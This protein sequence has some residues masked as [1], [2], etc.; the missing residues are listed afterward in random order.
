MVHEE[1]ERLQRLS[2]H[3]QVLLDA[4]AADDEEVGLLAARPAQQMHPAGQANGA[5]PAAS[6]S[7]TAA[8]GDSYADALLPAASPGELAGQV[9]GMQSG[10]ATTRKQAIARKLDGYTVEWDYSQHAHYPVLRL[11]HAV[12]GKKELT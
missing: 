7:G 2:V 6:V 3:M 9:A 5:S 12:T 10:V 8:A 1:R 11:K 4:A